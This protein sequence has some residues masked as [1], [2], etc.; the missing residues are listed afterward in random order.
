METKTLDEFLDL[1]VASTGEHRQKLA[2]AN[3]QVLKSETCLAHTQARAESVKRRVDALEAALKVIR[4]AQEDE[5][6]DD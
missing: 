1:L 4:K 6:G 2:E 5:E 3:A